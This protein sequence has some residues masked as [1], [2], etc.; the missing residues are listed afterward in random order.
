MAPTNK[1]RD[2]IRHD[3]KPGVSPPPAQ[4]V[5]RAPLATEAP[6]G[7]PYILSTSVLIEYLPAE[8]QALGPQLYDVARRYVGARRRSGEALLDA[9]RE[10]GFR[11]RL[12]DGRVRGRFDDDVGR[13]AF[14]QRRD[15]V[16]VGQVEALARTFVRERAVERRRHHVAE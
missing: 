5:E 11:F 14:D 10:V 15:R 9:V 16:Q 7:A 1:V 12:V 3:P 8:A 4:I 2:L 13:D 6:R